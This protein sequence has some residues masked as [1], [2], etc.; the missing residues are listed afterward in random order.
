MLKRKKKNIVVG[1]KHHAILKRNAKSFRRS[2]AAQFGVWCE[3]IEKQVVERLTPAERD[4]YFKGEMEFGESEYIK[5]RGR[6]DDRPA[7]PPPEPPRDDGGGE[8]DDE[9]V[10]E[11]EAA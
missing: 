9:R 3:A 10:E 5:R 8:R 11:F 7:P 1:E 4:A 6:R 2:L